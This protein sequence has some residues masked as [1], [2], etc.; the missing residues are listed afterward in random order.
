MLVIG[1][2]PAGLMAALAAARAGARVVIADESAAL[3]GSLLGETEEIDG[4]SG[5]EW[6]GK[7]AAELAAFPDVVVLPRTTVFGWYDGNIFGAVERVA[8]HKAVP[9]P[10][11]PRQRY[12]RILAGRA[13]MATG[14]EERPI[15]FGGND[16]PGVMLASAVRTYVNRYAA[17]P[18]ATGV[19]FTNND[20]GLSHGARS[21]RQRR[22][23]GGGH[24]QPPRC[25]QPR[26]RRR[27]RR[28]RRGHKPGGRGALP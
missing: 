5:A 2:G 1:A 6:A 21:H 13:V 7:A 10:H 22:P 3:G 11:E 9:S 18:G 27:P 25:R 4:A 14:A 12:W 15:V 19:V 28:G 17:A 24:R 16:R 23:R 26:C 20:F 8:D